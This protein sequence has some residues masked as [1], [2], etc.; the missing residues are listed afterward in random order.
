MAD[1]TDPFDSA[2]LERLEYL[3]IVSRRLAA[4]TIAG[5]RRGRRTGPGL[6]FAE[7]RAYVAGDDFRHI[8]W[9]AFGRLER[10]LLRLC[11]QEEDLG[12]DFLLDASASM[13]TGRPA[14]FDHARR[15][16][17][18]LAYVGLASLD[19]V[20]VFAV[21]DGLRA[22]LSAGR[23]R[24]NVLAILEFLRNLAPQGRTDLARSAQAYLAHA[25]R[26]GL[27]ILLSDLMDPGGYAR[28][29]TLLAGRGLE[30]WVLHVTDPADLAPPGAGD[31]AVADAETGEVLGVHLTEA[32]RERLAAEAERFAAEARAWCLGR[33][34]GYA[35]APTRTPADAMV[36]DILR[37]GGLV[38]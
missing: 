38:R 24:A 5:R 11:Q 28:P 32:V 33:G 23:D 16:A 19:R 7:H 35:E 37:R 10:L 36:L 2:F 31:A 29:L 4:G 18:A 12:I 22:H 1:A 13:A 9:A 34:I 14:K 27:A 25:G 30:A 21:G 20:R 8:D 17:A 26:P 3:R 6:E 15:L